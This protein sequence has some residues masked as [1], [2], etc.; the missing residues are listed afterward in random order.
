MDNLVLSIGKQRF[1]GWKGFSISRSMERGPHQFEM[2]LTEHW[3]GVNKRS[4]E[5]GQFCSLYLN[6]DRLVSGFINEVM[7]DYDAKQHSLRIVGR[8]KLQDLV[9]CSTTGRSFKN[10][11]FDAIATSLCK[12]FDIK[13]VNITD[14]GAKFTNV[15]INPG[16]SIWEF[17][18]YLARI[19]A[20]RIMEGAS[21][22]LLIT[23]LSNRRA[24]TPLI[25]GKN[26][27]SASAVHSDRDQFSEYIVVSQ[28][29][30]EDTLGAKAT[31]HSQGIAHDK[32]V[33]R[34]RPLVIVSDEDESP[35]DANTHAA[36]HANIHYGRS[37]KTTYTIEGWREANDKVWAPNT[38]V[39]VRDHYAK[40]NG[41]RA[42]SSVNLTLDEK[43]KRSEITVMPV[44]AF[45]LIPLPDPD[46]GEGDTL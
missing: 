37:E 42:I 15:T 33:K 20:I 38:R 14:V 41:E 45:D 11:T 16:Q 39:M 27:L 46:S 1:E 9:D 3:P 35:K 18:E 31:A 6:N 32:N 26:I 25:L 36:H 22:E 29:A 10:Q 13:V 4:I 24:S 30:D 5:K 19:R 7:P 12:P 17:L 34:Y 2:N 21:G 23:R 44:Q 8:S 43:G 40:V 28:Q